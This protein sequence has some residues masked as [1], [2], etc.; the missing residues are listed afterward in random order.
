MRR[1]HATALASVIPTLVLAVTTALH[2]QSMQDV[3]IK[4]HQVRGNVYMI[5]GRGGNIGLFVGKDG[6]FMIDDQFAPLTDRILT[7]VDG[8]TD[9]LVK[10]LINTHWHSDHTGGN[11]NIGKRGAIIVAH[12]NVRERLSTEQF[13]EAFGRTVPP[14]PDEALPVITFGDSLTFHWNDDDVHVIHVPHA[15]TDGDSIIHFTKTNV[16]HMGDIYFSEGYPFI[17]PS[18][19]G[20]ID[21]VIRG[22]N[23][24]LE[25]SNDKTKYIAGHGK[26]TGREALIEYRDMLVNVRERINK[27]IEAGKTRKE[28]IAARPTRN[29]DEQWG[30]GF[31]KPDQWVG[32]VYDGIQRNRTKL[33]D[34]K[35]GAD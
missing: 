20:I 35:S 4:S 16:I 26:T 28:I 11:E 31:M 13:M 22:V 3:E 24:A 21:G 15:H 6:A 32:L 30:G 1:I 23:K 12:K 19:G 8:I 17:D 14:S 29:F 5:E 18:S 34:H 10:F 27:M 25:I 9:K 7:A 33:Q 2:A